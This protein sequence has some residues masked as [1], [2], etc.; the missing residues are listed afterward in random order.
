MS[1]M[2][3]RLHRLAAI[4]AAALALAACGPRQEAPATPLPSP[5]AQQ[6][7]AVAGLPT[8]TAVPSQATLTPAQPTAAPVQPTLAPAQPTAAAPL[9]TAAPPTGQPGA[10]QGPARI[11]FAPNATSA[12]VE[13][14][15]IRGERRFYVLW[16]AA[17]QKMDVQLSSLEQNGAVVI[18]GPD[19]RPLPGAEPGADAAAWSGLLP[20]T[21]DYTFEVGP[22]RGN[23]TYR[24][25]VSIVT[26]AA[27]APPAGNIRATDWPAALAS[28][29]ALELRQQDG[30][31]YVNVRGVTPGVGG[32]PLFDG[33]VYSD[34]DGDGRED[35]AI[36]LESG[37]TA[38]NIGLL[39]FRDSGA[40]PSLA[41]WRDGYKLWAEASGGL[42]VVRQPIYAGWDPNCCPSGLA[43][44]SYALRAGGLEVVQSR[45]EGVAGAEPEVVRNYYDLIRR[46]ELA[47]AYA[48]LAPAEQAAN[49]YAQ[50]AAGFASTLDLSAITS[51]DPAAP[52]A[53]RVELT[54]TDATP[55]GGQVVRRFAGSWRVRWD[56]GRAG[57]ALEAPQIAER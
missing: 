1:T 34:F 41:A 19:G 55:E 11:S 24:L 14:A 48:L 28:A 39:V 9:P 27:P 38:G 30:R 26:P 23:T 36:M 50:W 8:M 7:T 25:S 12:A 21:G 20:A 44:T 52:G 45:S 35:A 49:P 31:L 46:K 32:M 47:A 43:F 10:P 37:G 3:A 15:A 6:A 2:L 22:T 18:N 56:G 53:V 17:G 57:W 42:L 51:A 33:I 29:P 40:G 13:G 4:A 16:A 5:T 54:A